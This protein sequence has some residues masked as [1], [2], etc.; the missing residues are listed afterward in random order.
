MG[1]DCRRWGAVSPGRSQP[2]YDGT[3]SCVGDDT[4][5]KSDAPD[6]QLTSVTAGNFHSCAIRIDGTISCSGSDRYS[7][8]NVPDGQFRA[9]SASGVYSCAIRVGGTVACWATITTANWSRLRGT[10]LLR[11]G[12]R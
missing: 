4:Y 9:I 12:L 7:E 2:T 5:G 11:G 8:L 6:G 10:V 1:L 3:T